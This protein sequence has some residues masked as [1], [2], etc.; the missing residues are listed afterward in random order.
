HNKVANVFNRTLQTPKHHS[1][2]DGISNELPYFWKIRMRLSENCDVAFLAEQLRKRAN[3]L[4]SFPLRVLAESKRKEEEMR[5]TTSRI[6]SALFKSALLLQNY[7]HP[8]GISL[9]E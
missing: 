9:Y 1:Y 6:F 7:D 5:I 4:T 3:S 2:S 8:L